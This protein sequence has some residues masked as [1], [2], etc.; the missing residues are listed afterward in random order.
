MEAGGSGGGSNEDPLSTNLVE[1]LH[2]NETIAK[3]LNDTSQGKGAGQKLEK[4]MESWDLLQIRCALYFNGDLTGLPQS[5][6]PKKPSRG[7]YQRLKGKQGRFRGNLSG[8]RVNFSGRTVIS[9][10][11]N[12][13]IDE[14]AV[15]LHVCKILTFPE[16]VSEY[17]IEH[18]RKLVIN[19]PEVHP[20]ADSIVIGATGHKKNLRYGNREITAKNLRHGDIVH[21]HI[22]DGDAVLFNRQ[23]S[24]H[25]LS[26]MCHKVKVR[27][28]RTFRFNEC[29]CKPYNADFDGDEMNL[30]V[31]QTVEA[32]AEAS[33]L[34]SVSLLA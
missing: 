3:H 8:K 32:A 27:P 6:Q 5:Q 23:P 21:R 9:P 22:I 16:M 29:V 1:I 33:T 18:L 31:P 34:M 17:N 10:D 12:L 30:H 13:G 2:C 7:F 26:I 24:L 28:W 20:G 15:P 19:G 25:K 4:I 11:P 14:V